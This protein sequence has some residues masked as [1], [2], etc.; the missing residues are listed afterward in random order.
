MQFIVTQEEF[1]G[2]TVE[3]PTMIHKLLQNCSLMPLRYWMV[4]SNDKQCNNNLY[5]IS[6]VFL[7]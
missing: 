3:A 1:Y 6:K 4:S 7:E 5:I 2:Y